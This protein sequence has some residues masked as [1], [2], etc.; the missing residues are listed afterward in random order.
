MTG[1]QPYRK[2]QARRGVP[3]ASLGVDSERVHQL[4]QQHSLEENTQR[5]YSSRLKQAR[6][7]IAEAAKEVEKLAELK[8]PISI[9]LGATSDVF[10]SAFGEVPNRYSPHAVALYLTHIHFDRKLGKSTV[11]QTHAALKNMWNSV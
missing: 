9:E 8:P 7:W 10:A 3:G 11:E 1:N 4:T 6:K 5:A 2:A